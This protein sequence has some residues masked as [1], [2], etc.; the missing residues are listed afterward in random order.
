[1]LPDA[2]VQDI[3][4]ASLRHP[5]DFQQE[6]DDTGGGTPVLY[7]KEGSTLPELVSRVFG[8][9]PKASP[10]LR[11]PDP[12]NQVLVEFGVCLQSVYG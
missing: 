11:L 12:V 1:M 7:M 6:V 5:R 8:L 3:R 9:D 4:F 10:Q 2:E